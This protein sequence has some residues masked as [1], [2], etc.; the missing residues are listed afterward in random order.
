MLLCHETKQVTLCAL[1][2]HKVLLRTQFIDNV[3]RKVKNG[4][5]SIHHP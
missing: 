5:G 4:G 3:Q 1:H 2:L